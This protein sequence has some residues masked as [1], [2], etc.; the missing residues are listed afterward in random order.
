MKYPDVNH[1]YQQS[2]NFTIIIQG[3]EQ[4]LINY[5]KDTLSK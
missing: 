2:G 4:I 3:L 1:T 5:T